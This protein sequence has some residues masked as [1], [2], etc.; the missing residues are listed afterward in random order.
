MRKLLKLM[1]GLVLIIIIMFGGILLLKTHC[2]NLFEE[3]LQGFKEPI[4][5]II[6]P[7]KN[8]IIEKLLFVEKDG[9]VSL[10]V[11]AECYLGS[12][13][14]TI[15][16]ADGSI[17]YK[18]SGKKL[19]FGGSEYLTK[20]QYK[21]SLKFN[22]VVPAL[23]IMQVN[24]KNDQPAVY[25][26][27][28]YLD[29]R[30]YTRAKPDPHKG[31]YW[32]YYLYVPEGLNHKDVK[33]MLVIPNNTGTPNDNITFHENAAVTEILTGRGAEC[34]NQLEVPLLVPIFP[35]QQK[36]GYIYTHALDRDSMTTEIED[37]KRIDLQLISMIDDARERLKEKGFNL[38]EKILMS[39]FSAS[40]SFTSRFTI[41]HP[42]RI[43]AAAVGSPGGW[44]IVP[45]SSYNGYKLRYPIGVADLESLVGRSF[46]METFKKV[47]MYFYIGSRDKNDSVPFDDSY[48][49]EDRPVIND[50]FGNSPVE[51]WPLAEQI[52]KKCNCSAEFVTYPLV[53]HRVTRK[54]GKDIFDF[55]RKNK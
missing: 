8:D 44:P 28:P 40:G 48:E 1:G 4:L 42:D 45:I 36:Y 35:R 5:S 38:D 32:P 34:A 17:V 41:L 13:D 52:Y 16:D 21:L 7:A 51:R 50:N 53:G 49:A 55:F 14:L 24:N 12:I 2:F 23:A 46:D 43:K 25:N 30:L 15:Y 11:W 31:F 10:K 18:K 26:L 3:H 33:Y 20:G 29:K 6:Y 47:P 39:G 54:M 37:L 22:K 27:I 19:D 9:K